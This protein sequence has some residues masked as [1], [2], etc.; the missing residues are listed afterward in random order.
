MTRRE[1]ILSQAENSG[2]CESCEDALP[3]DWALGDYSSACGGCMS[4]LFE[5]AQREMGEW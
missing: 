1:L 5:T 3:F 2:L 4:E